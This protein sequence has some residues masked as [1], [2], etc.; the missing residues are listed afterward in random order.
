MHTDVSVGTKIRNTRE[1]R[2]ISQNELAQLLGVSA[3][4]VCYWET[5]GTTPRA[6][7]LKKVAEALGVSESYLSAGA[8]VAP[9]EGFDSV[10]AYIEQAKAKIATIIGVDIDRISINITL[11]G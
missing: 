1:A 7:T 8:E 6:K 2:K 5:K 3:A 9:K 10:A 11:R 4:A